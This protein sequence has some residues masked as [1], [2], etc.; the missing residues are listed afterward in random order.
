MTW[1]V[2]ARR[3][4]RVLRADDALLVYP[5]FLVLFAAVT[6]Y[7]ATGGRGGASL[8]ATLSL[9]GLLAVPFVASALTH[10]A[11]PGALASGRL[12]LTLS[13]PHSRRAFLG[14]AAV[15]RFAA[16]FGSVAAA[17]AVA[18][19]V[20]AV[21]GG[22]LAPVRTLA[23]LAL[24]ALLAAAFVAATLALTAR[25]TS[26]TYAAAAAVGFV[27]AAYAWPAAVQ[28]GDS[29][30][31]SHLGAGVPDAAVLASPVYAY[32]SAASSA[33]GPPATAVGDAVVGAFVLAAWTAVGFALAARRF[34][35]VEL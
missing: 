28:F 17:A 18:T 25:S 12:R 19:A 22:A 1:P 21:R 3:D 29:L 20:Y 6:A 2:I 11:V 7:D 5:G 35:R 31:G 30:A 24:A 33:G 9:L 10:E 32:A 27:V 8:A 34:G 16:A 15:A 23:T 26:T 14:G 4:V 13:L